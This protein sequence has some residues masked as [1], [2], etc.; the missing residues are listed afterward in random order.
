MLLAS[1]PTGNE[2][3]SPSQALNR[4]LPAPAQTTGKPPVTVPETQPVEPPSSPGEV[5][6]A[7]PTAFSIDGT[8]I[9][10]GG[11]GVTVSGTPISLQGSGV[12]DIGNS[13]VT[14]SSAGPTD[15]VGL[16]AFTGFGDHSAM[17]SLYSVLASALGLLIIM[18]V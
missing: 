8:T 16:A 17:V 14:L 7:N 18:T 3:S 12:L 4:H 6:T 1:L 13:T 10:A 11:P 5:F 15:G 2:D 9:S